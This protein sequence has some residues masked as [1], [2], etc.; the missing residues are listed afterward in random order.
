MNRYTEYKR[1][2]FE[3]GANSS[4]V[5]DFDLQFR[6]HIN[7]MTLSEFFEMLEDIENGVYAKGQDQ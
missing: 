6:D 4:A 7:A 3:H 1:W 5:T 2:W